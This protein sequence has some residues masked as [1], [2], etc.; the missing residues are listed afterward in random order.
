MNFSNI[1]KFSQNNYNT[2]P[3]IES[4]LAFM[5]YFVKQIVILNIGFGFCVF[6]CIWEHTLNVF[7]Y[8]VRR[9]R[10]R[11]PSSSSS[12]VRPSVPSSVPSSSSVL[13]P[14]V[15]SSVPSSSSSVVVVRRRRPSSSVVVCRRPSKYYLQDLLLLYFINS[16]IYKLINI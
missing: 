7:W 11:V 1:Y 13:C 9:R 8:F 15:P 4:I 5:A 10:R 12:S 3:Q 16:E 14:S 2:F 6:F